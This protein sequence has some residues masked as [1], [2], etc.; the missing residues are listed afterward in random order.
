LDYPVQ[1]I[2]SVLI[3]PDGMTA[4]FRVN[5]E[6]GSLF[7]SIEAFKKSAIIQYCAGYKEIPDVVK[8]AVLL[9]LKRNLLKEMHFK[10]YDGKMLSSIKIGDYTETA[11]SEFLNL[12]EKDLEEQIRLL[13]RIPC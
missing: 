2:Y 1:E 4:P 10:N 9:I 13:S 3:L 6:S 5:K 12:L 8:D 7:L 11:S